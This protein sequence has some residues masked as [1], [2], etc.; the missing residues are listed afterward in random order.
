MVLKK[1]LVF[2]EYKSPTLMSVDKFEPSLSPVGSNPARNFGFFHVTMLSNQ[3]TELRT[4]D[5]MYEEVPEF[6]FR[7]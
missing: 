2:M 6:F 7:Q 4:P 1:R 5:I 3:L